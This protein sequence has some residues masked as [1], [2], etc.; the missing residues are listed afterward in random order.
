MTGPQT[1]FKSLH[2]LLSDQWMIVEKNRPLALVGEGAEPL[3]DIRVAVRRF[4]ALLKFSGP[5]LK[6]EV[7]DPLNRRLGLWTNHMG[8]ARDLDVW[9]NF[10]EQCVNEPE[11]KGSDTFSACRKFYKKKRNAYVQSLSRVLSGGPFK[12]IQ[13][14]VHHF[15]HSKIWETST[16][17]SRFLSILHERRN[18][19]IPKLRQLSPSIIDKDS[20]TLHDLRKRFKKHRYLAEFLSEF[21]DVSSRSLSRY[22]KSVTHCLGLIHDMD[23]FL[24][25][26]KKEKDVIPFVISE[27]ISDV[28]GA[29]QKLLKDAIISLN[30][31]IK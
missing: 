31:F 21:D 16:I 28:R 14:S 9:I 19:L 24:E 30:A 3:H 6:T 7:T 11:V 12:P 2:Q 22:L 1:Q 23:I 27:Y 10:L 15:L 18:R 20:E 29:H 4:R 8:D 25:R 13:K 17:D 26:Y 5:I